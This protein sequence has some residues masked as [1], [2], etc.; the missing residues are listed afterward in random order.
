MKQS[1]YEVKVGRV[2]K[3]DGKK[4]QYEPDGML[5]PVKIERQKVVCI[6]PHKKHFIGCPQRHPAN[7]AP[8]DVVPDLITPKIFLIIPAEGLATEL[9]LFA[10]ALKS[11]KIEVKTTYNE[12][13]KYQVPHIHLCDPAELKCDTTR[14]RRLE[15]RPGDQRKQNKWEDNRKQIGTRE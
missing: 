12:Y 13:E 11:I 1:M 3:W 9:A 6:T 14:N 10:L 8:K 4:Y 2:K 15:V 5:A 7:T